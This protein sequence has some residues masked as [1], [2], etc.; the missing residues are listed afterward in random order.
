MGRRYLGIDLGTK[1]IGL[2]VGE[3]DGVVSPVRTIAASGD[4]TRD[5]T[6]IV[7]AAAEY[8]ATGIV[9]GLPLNMDDTEGPQAKLARRVAEAVR[10]VA[11][12]SQPDSMPD[13][14]IHLHDERLT[15]HAADGLLTGR[16]LTH[17]QKKARHDAMAAQVLLASFLASHGETSS[18]GS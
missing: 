4:V 9:I 16:E 2:A 7:Q 11:A 15:S 5:A 3:A 12:L 18:E 10:K 14:E 6:A 8:D 1:R 13:Y 17:K